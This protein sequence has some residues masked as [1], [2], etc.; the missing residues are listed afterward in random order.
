MNGD[1]V[2]AIRKFLF[3]TAN[4]PADTP[5]PGMARILEI[6][7]HI[8]YY[9]E[10]SQIK[11]LNLLQQM[12]INRDQQQ[13][14]NQDSMEPSPLSSEMKKNG[15][16]FKKLISQRKLSIQPMNPVYYKS[17]VKQHDESKLIQRFSMNKKTD[18][19]KE[20][21]ISIRYL[22]KLGK[23]RRK[24]KQEQSYPNT[25]ERVLGDEVVFNFADVKREP[26]LELK[27]D[28][29]ELT[30]I[31]LAKEYRNYDEKIFKEFQEKHKQDIRRKSMMLH[32][33]LKIS[34]ENITGPKV[35]TFH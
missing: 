10:I 17:P 2:S 28:N 14:S 18:E 27:L 11:S 12:S 32:D 25:A 9:A 35:G 1:Y 7:K 5:P 23:Q 20:I 3:A 19:D 26:E 4:P 29:D 8:P 22:R 6:N 30:Y 13:E 16:L 34:F 24:M 15:R 21:K 33:P 31:D